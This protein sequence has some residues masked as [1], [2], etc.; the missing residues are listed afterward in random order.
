M[1]RPRDLGYLCVLV[2]PA[3][4]PAAA[5]MIAAGAPAAAAGWFPLLF[6]FVLVPLADWLLGPD[7]HNPS[8]TEAPRLESALAY[9]A[10]TWLVL[11]LWLTL[12]GWSLHYATT[13]ALPPAALV[14]WLLSTGVIGG[15]LAINTAHELIHKDGR[16]EPALG[17]ALLASV[18]YA[19]FKVE[20]L[21]GHHVHVSTPRDASSARYGESVYGFVPRALARNL[22]NAWRLEAERLRRRGLPWLHWRNELLG[23]Y[24]LSA[25]FA[26]AA[27]LALGPRGVLFFLLQ[28]LVAGATLEVINYIEHYGLHRRELGPGRYERVDARHSWNSDFR[29]TNWMLFQLQRHADHHANARRRYQVLRHFDD[30]PQ[31]PAG[32]ATMFVLALLPP[33]WRRIIDPRVR[34]HL[35]ATQ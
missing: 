3:L 30:S 28:G 33:L 32:Y 26:L 19:G 23:W 21:R 31:L 4:L 17:G 22:A 20:H 35:A 6:L 2:V 14:G 11:P 24:G 29:L 34:R 27:G 9:R 5:G 1:I 15:V 10:L 12:L 18:V 8:E 13:Q 16:L 7:A 25:L